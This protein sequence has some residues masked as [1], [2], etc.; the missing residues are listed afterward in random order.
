M[1]IVH[2]KL[3]GV[4]SKTA[5]DNLC[6]DLSFA[7][8]EAFRLGNYEQFENN[9]HNHLSTYEEVFRDKLLSDSLSVFQDSP[10]GRVPRLKHENEDDEYLYGIYDLDKILDSETLSDHVLDFLGYRIHQLFYRC[11]S[12]CINGL[13]VKTQDNEYSFHPGFEGVSR[14]VDWFMQANLLDFNQ[15]FSNFTAWQKEASFFQLV[16]SHYPEQFAFHESNHIIEANNN[17]N[18]NDMNKNI[19]PELNSDNFSFLPIHLSAET[20][21]NTIRQIR[22]LEQNTALELIEEKQVMLETIFKRTH[23]YQKLNHEQHLDDCNN[24]DSNDNHPNHGTK[25][26]VMKI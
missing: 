22:I 26:S 17:N 6:S 24:H 3:I 9:I 23:L 14:A 13:S 16:Y 19:H 15:I 5:Q 18:N 11:V 7:I 21:L 4:Y 2:S 20:W 12:L 25:T 10:S 1:K 8:V